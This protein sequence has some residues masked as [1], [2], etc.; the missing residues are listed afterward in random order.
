MNF[1]CSILVQL[2]KFEHQN[3]QPFQPYSGI[4]GALR[5]TDKYITH[6]YYYYYAHFNKNAMFPLDS[7]FRL[8]R[9]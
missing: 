6:Y 8:D 9:E 2:F 3:R 1:L 7:L 4:P 5:S